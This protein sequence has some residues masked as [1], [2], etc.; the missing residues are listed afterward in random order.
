MKIVRY[1]LIPASLLLEKLKKTRLMGHQQAL[2]YEHAQITLQ[3]QVAPGLLIPAQRYVLQ[4]H[5]QIIEN[6]YAALLSQGLDIFALTGGVW[7]WYE[8][9]EAP[10]PLTPPI[11]EESYEADGRKIWLISDGMHRVYTARKLGK[12]INVILV[13]DVP[14]PYYAF[15]LPQAWAEVVELQ[16]IP[17]AFPKKVYRESNYKDLFRNYNEIFSGIQKSRK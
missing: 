4:A 6:L 9:G 13:Q 10:L 16:E 17:A 12:P 2:I 7:F 14:Y 1:D 8:G 5:L 11:I 3:E 15:P